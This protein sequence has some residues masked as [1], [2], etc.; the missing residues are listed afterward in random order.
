MSSNEYKYGAFELFLTGP[1]ETDELDLEIL[2]RKVLEAYID[3]GIDD[4]TRRRFVAHNMQVEEY[5]A[6]F[7]KEECFN[8]KET[9]I[10]RLDAI[11]H[12]NAK[13]NADF[14]LHGYSG[15]IVAEKWL[16]EMKKSPELALSVRRAIERHMGDKGYPADLLRKIAGRDACFPSP[17]SK[18]AELVYCCD[19]MTQLTPEG[20][21]KIVHLR[22]INYL[23]TIEDKKTAEE[24]GISIQDATLLSALASTKKS[25][26]IIKKSKIESVKKFAKN[27]WLDIEKRY[28]EYLPLLD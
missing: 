14:L 16:L 22:E 4:G 19:I 11:L 23:D 13:G 15:G 28:F 2:R 9:E 8:E 20:I 25:Y 7:S 26:E 18:I 5:V 12:D 24:K 1:A 21:N 10:S 3:R 17:A 6:I 27:S